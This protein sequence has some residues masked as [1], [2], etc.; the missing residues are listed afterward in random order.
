MWRA[1]NNS[2]ESI[3]VTIQTFPYVLKAIEDNVMALLGGQAKAMVVTSSRKEAVRYKLGFDT[4]IAKKGYQHIHAMIAFSGE[5]EFRHKDPNVEALL[6]Q[7][8]TEHNM[9]PNLKKA[10]TYAE[11]LIRMVIRLWSWPTNFQTG[12]DQ[13]K[14]CSMYVDN[15]K[16]PWMKMRL[17]W[18]AWVLSHYRLSV[19][20]QQDI[21]LQVDAPE[22]NLTPGEGLGSGTAKDLKAEFLSQIITRLNELFITDELT[23]NDLANYLY[24]IADKISENDVVMQQ[25]AHNSPEQAM[26]GDFSKAIDDAVM[27]SSKAHQIQMM[28]LLSAC[29]TAASILWQHC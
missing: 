7:K 18:T 23:D 11:R 21:Q 24:T 8:F 29:N 20:R 3:I 22:Y 13:P 19:I 10:E 12:F 1:T 9:N 6:E 4:Y 5:I 25:I 16:R 15:V 14:L 28:Q 26:L 2:T 27:G 17:T